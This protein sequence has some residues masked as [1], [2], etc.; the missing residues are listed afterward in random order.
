MPK[1]PTY[2]NTAKAE[3]RILLTIGTI[4]QELRTA[5]EKVANDSVLIFSSY[6]PRGR[7]GR[8]G[9][10]IRAVTAQTRENT[11]RFGFGFSFFIIASA[12]NQ[13][14]DY[15]GVSRFGHRLKF[16]R[17][18]IQRQPQSVISTRRPK[19]RYGD[20]TSEGRRARPALRIPSRAG[21]KPLYRNV[22]RG[23]IKTKD[24]AAAAQDSVDREMDA[25][26]VRLAHN[27]ERRF[28]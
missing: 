9:R 20:T 1:F 12:K 14:F 21:G 11:G 4:P 2:I 22:V 26:A 16:I 6:A 24:W 18:S 5:V 10:G 19:L 15:V 27:L 13:G 17:P 25:Q 3:D 23:I 28:G 8:I 7:T